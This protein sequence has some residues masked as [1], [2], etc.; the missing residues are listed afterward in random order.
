MTL[1]G[2][3]Y[4]RPTTY[5]LHAEP[6]SQEPPMLTRRTFIR[7][8]SGAVAGCAWQ[9][10]RAGD[11]LL[12]ARPKM[13]TTSITAGEHA[14][15]IG[16][17]RDGLLVIPEQYRPGTAAPLAL[18]LHGAGGRARRIVTLLSVAESLGVIVLA[19]ES[20]GSTWDAIRAQYGPD[21]EFVNRALE[22]T[23]ERCSIDRRRLGIGGF[24]DGATYA[25]S[26]GL[27]NGSLFTHILAFSPGFSVA[28][29]PQGRPRIFISHGKADQILPIDS[30]SRR[31]VPALEDAGYAV[32]YREF[33][34]PHTV[35]PAI[36]QEA[37]NWFV[38]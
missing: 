6:P 11:S 28:R 37:F 21:V 10:A 35:P 30:T 34:G 3:W 13:P 29:R 27:D 32:N 18:L 36:A 16:S 14:L 33:D 25:L 20:R 17:D 22:Y 38:R 19:P 23:F 1:D 24:S 26:L 5:G 12:H 31:L 2:R 4:H 8:A 9:P 7:F 15:G